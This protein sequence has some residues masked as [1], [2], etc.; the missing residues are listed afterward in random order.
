M[1]RGQ[2]RKCPICEGDLGPDSEVCPRCGANASLLQTGDGGE[3][4][5]TPMSPGSLDDILASV[6][7]EPTVKQSTKTTK[8]LSLED[9]DLEPPDE[10]PTRPKLELDILKEDILGKEEPKSITFECPECG[11][12]VNEA[13]SLCPSCGALFAEGGSFECPVCGSNVSVEASRC[14]RCGVRFE[15]ETS[16]TAETTMLERAR[17]VYTGEE[18]LPT[19][20]LEPVHQTGRVGDEAGPLVARVMARYSERK[21]S[22]PLLAG[23]I[24]NLHASLR[25][26]VE[27]IRSLVS[28]AN[29]LHVPVEN[30]KN[31]IADATKKA[32]AQDLSGAVKLAWSARLSLEQSLAL[33]IAQGLEML[34]RDLHSRREEG[35]TF[36]VAEALVRDAMKEVQDGKVEDSFE[37]LQMARDDV[38]SKASGQSEAHYA[39][40]AAEQFIAEIAEMNVDVSG[41]R[42][43]LAQG[44]AA[45]RAGDWETA[46]Q[47]AASVQERANKG[48]QQGIADEMQRARQTVM[49]LKVRGQDISGPINLLKQA[50][51]CTKEEQYAEAMNYL[52][53]FKKQ[54]EG[55]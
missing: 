9:L 17:E 48:L 55:A 20:D 40:Q 35:R 7:D 26:Q 38:S 15:E 51:A 23:D 8:E 14:P 44:K 43:V 50:S 31:V 12:E 39:I 22:S 33:Q 32:R 6:L 2:T 37:K 54:V 10:P 47:L 5:S 42:E 25:D 34:E 30:T 18:E 24:S 11:T 52:R 49:E 16:A 1:V 41:F 28:V 45:L 13:A 53:L 27:A 29:R 21:E 4:E 36:P 19:A 46:S 3:D